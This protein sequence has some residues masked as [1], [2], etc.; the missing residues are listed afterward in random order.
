MCWNSSP[1]LKTSVVARPKHAT[2]VSP[3][4]DPLPASSPVVIRRMSNGVVTS[5]RCVEESN[6]A[7]GRVAHSGGNGCIAQSSRQKDASGPN[8][9]CAPSVSIQHRGPR[10]EAVQM[11][12]RDLQIDRSAHD[13]AL[14][15][16]RGKGGKVRQCPLWPETRRA[17]AE[18]IAGRLRMMSSS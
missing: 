6:G 9:A 15:T 5:E 7:T 17:L 4:S 1:I 13:H 3:P 8:G 14:V 16:L 11:K 10:F 2:S 12:V 18:I